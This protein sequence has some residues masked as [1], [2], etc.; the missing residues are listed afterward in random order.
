MGPFTRIWNKAVDRFSAYVDGL[1]GSDGVQAEP[2]RP[3]DWRMNHREYAM[4]II[5]LACGLVAGLRYLFLGPGWMHLAGVGIL[6][7]ELLAMRGLM[8]YLFRPVDPVA[9]RVQAKQNEQMKLSNIWKDM[10]GGAAQRMRAV[11]GTAEGVRA[12]EFRDK[13]RGYDPAKVDMLIE[14]IADELEAGRSPR[15]LLENP[16]LGTKLRGYHPV[17]VDAFLASMR[18]L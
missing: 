4:V 14:K 13:L 9:L 10:R 18:R 7:L 6:L 1:P 17:D 15:R 12:V 2:R 11:P 3:L 5:V 8:R 16:D